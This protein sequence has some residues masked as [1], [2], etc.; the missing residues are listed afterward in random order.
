M[1]GISDP[2]SDLLIGEVFNPFPD[3][4]FCNPSFHQGKKLLEEFLLN[5]IRGGR[6]VTLFSFRSVWEN[7]KENLFDCLSSFNGF[8]LETN[9]SVLFKILLRLQEHPLSE[10]TVQRVGVFVGLFSLHFHLFEYSDNLLEFLE[11]KPPLSNPFVLFEQ[12]V[13][14]DRV[15]T[16]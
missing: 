8:E 13:D 1:E 2:F 11:V 12:F 3:G 15:G 16:W 10:V 14:P 4:F 7:G 6:V 5:R 9:V